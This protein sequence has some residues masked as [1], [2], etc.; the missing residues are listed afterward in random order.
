MPLEPVRRPR[1]ARTRRQTRRRWQ[2]GGPILQGGRSRGSDIERTLRST[3]VNCRRRRAARGLDVCCP[4]R[5]RRRR[6]CCR[7][8]E[9]R[10]RD[11]Q[12]SSRCCFCCPFCNRRLRGRCVP[13]SLFHALARRT[14][15]RDGSKGR[16]ESSTRG[17][18]L[19]EADWPP[20][21]KGR[22]RGDDLSYA[23][24]RNASLP[25]GSGRADGAP[26]ASK[27]E[28]SAPRARAFTKTAAAAYA[29]AQPRPGR[30]QADGLSREWTI[31]RP[32]GCASLPSTR[33]ELRAA[34][35]PSAVERGRRRSSLHY[36]GT[37][38]ERGR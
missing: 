2:M 20:E 34:G 29:S 13:P 31:A 37:E 21:R 35:C 33:C 24:R 8:S 28:E 10:P 30:G 7:C 12:S 25:A 4:R 15:S 6:R 27:R 16:R 38:R 23:A 11:D 26:C 1:P 36:C 19:G 18:S 14:G 3:P 17:R 32:V 9:Q 5:R 22:Q